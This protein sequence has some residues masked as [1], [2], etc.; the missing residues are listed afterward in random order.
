MFIFILADDDE[1]NF[2]PDDIITNIEF[3]SLFFVQLIFIKMH[4]KF[5]ILL[6]VTCNRSVVFSGYSGFLHQ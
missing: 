1:L 2:D 5:A 4:I 6:S 3:V